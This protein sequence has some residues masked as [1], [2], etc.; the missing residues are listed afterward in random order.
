[1]SCLIGGFKLRAGDKKRAVLASNFKWGWLLQ[2]PFFVGRVQ[3]AGADQSLGH[4][5]VAQR[6]GIGRQLGRDEAELV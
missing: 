2:A 5:M 3:A 4:L 1:M 6:Q